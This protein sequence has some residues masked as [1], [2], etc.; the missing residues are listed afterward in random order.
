[1]SLGFKTDFSNAK[2]NNTKRTFD[3][4]CKHSHSFYCVKRFYYAALLHWVTQDSSFCYFQSALFNARKHIIWCLF[5]YYANDV[6]GVKIA[7]SYLCLHRA[8]SHNKNFSSTTTWS[9]LD[10]DASTNQPFEITNIHLHQNI[11]RISK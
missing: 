4:N 10:S 8:I 7:P 9:S 11:C 5:F 3:Y 2:H 1:M 6:Y